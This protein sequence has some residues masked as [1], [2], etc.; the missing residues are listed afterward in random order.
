MKR[1]LYYCL[2]LLCC[3][4]TVRGATTVINAFNSGELSPL[5]EGRIDVK[6]Y[7]SGC[8][9]L[10]NMVVLPHGGVTKR[11]GTYYIANA[12][13]NSVQGRLIPFEYSTEQAYVIEMGNLCMRFYRD[14]GQILD[15]ADD[16]Y[17][18]TTVFSENEF[19][20]VQY[21]Q[22]ADTMYLVSGTDPPQQ[23]TRTAHDAWTIAD[24]DIVDGP[25]LDEN[26][27][28]TQDVNATAVTG[29]VTLNSNFQMFDKDHVGS[30]WQISHVVDSN[31]ISGILDAN[32]SSA[33]DLAVFGDYTFTTH[34]TWTGYVALERSEDDGSTWEEVPAGSRYGKDDTNILDEG[35]EDVADVIYQVT[36]SQYASGDCTYHLVVDMHVHAGIVEITA[37]SDPN[38]VTATVITTLASTDS[39]YRWAEGYW[40]DYRGWPT[41]IA[42]YE[43]RLVFAGSSAYPQTLWFSQTDDWENFDIGADD[44]DA[45]IFAI[46]ADQVNAIRW[47]ASQTALLM[48]TT[49]GEWKISA[50]SATEPLT[51]TNVTV[52]R[53]STHGCANLQPVV[54][55]DVILYLQRQRKKVRQLQYA[56]ERDVWISPD[57][58]LVSEH[59]TGDG[60]VQLAL[61][62]NPYTI[63]W[64][65]RDD[66]AL[67]GL[68]LEETQEVVGWHRHEFRGDVESATVIPGSAGSELWL[69]VNRSI[70]NATVRYIEQLQPFAWGISQEDSFFVDSGLTY[71][72]GAAIIIS[73]ITKA[74]PAVVT[75][76]AH[77][78][79]DGAQ[80]RVTAV[81]GMTELNNN[82][83]TIGTVV[84]TDRF[85][86]RDKTDAVNINSTGFTTYMSGG[87]FTPVENTFTTLSHLKSETVTALGDGGYAGS[88]I[89]SSNGTVTLSDYYN[90]VHVGKAYTAKIQP[91][92]L[93]VAASPGVLFAATQR[94]TDI[95]LRLHKSL[96]CDVGTS[97]SVYDSHVFRDADDPL[98]APPPLYSGDKYMDFSGDYEKAGNIFIQSRLPVPFT[99]LALRAEFE[100]SQ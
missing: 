74:N 60:I 3:I 51:P 11:P 28:T 95:T 50:T 90:T 18:I 9:T 73:K 79:S 58:T 22:S 45:M 4:S 53:Q 93:A 75:A 8:R 30:L 44:T 71:D 27:T 99:L 16:P 59:I 86:L 89:I 77:G 25:F 36:M 69:F 46:A 66:G 12:K 94:I 29:S 52:R 76:A 14:S 85:Q 61:Q 13:S 24:M 37:Y 39:T 21:V 49:G 91:M 57:L 88:Y 40:S 68:T 15:D 48:G 97:W 41:C 78:L 82:V 32:E 20:V 84:G 81:V 33:S 6:K 34:G 5:L 96:T 26:T 17:E 7:Y 98:E 38:T 64:C 87:I 100:V 62:K 2:V 92:K 67:V 83:Y 19:F 23:L 63:L 31:A 47:L 56:W 43:E 10:E 80:V 65:V 35:S 1:I 54:T 42:F 55:N 70:D 72:G